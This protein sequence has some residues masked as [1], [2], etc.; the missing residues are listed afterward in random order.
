MQLQI[1]LQRFQHR[2]VLTCSVTHTETAICCF[3]AA[4]VLILLYV[5]LTVPRKINYHI[6]SKIISIMDAEAIFPF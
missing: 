1:L 4:S 2:A 6:I 5:L 3:Y